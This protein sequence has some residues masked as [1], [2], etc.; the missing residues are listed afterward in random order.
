MPRL[1]PIRGNAD[2][3]GGRD[4]S[5]ADG[6]GGWVSEASTQLP[7]VVSILSRD[8]YP[9]SLTGVKGML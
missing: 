7:A 8:L 9:F 2:V 6:E 4:G 5:R 3:S 1:C